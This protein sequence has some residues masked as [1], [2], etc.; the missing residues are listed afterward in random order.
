MAIEFN[1]QN[2]SESNSF[3]RTLNLSKGQ[4]LNLEKNGNAI[5]NLLV[6][7]GWDANQ[8]G[9]TFDLDASV[10]LLNS[11]GVLPE[12]DAVVYFNNLKAPGMEH[13]GD[14]LTGDGDGDDEQIT[15][16]LDQV[17]SE[18]DRIVFVVNIYDAKAKK[19]SFGSVKNSYISLTDTN[20]GRK[21]LQYNLKDDYSLQT[22]VIVA[23]L[24]RTTKGWTFHAIGEG[25]VGDLNDLVARYS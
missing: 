16:D 17:G 21:L 8:Y 5:K 3:S 11:K 12:L 7:L 18:I 22:G 13:H 9:A 1:N 15:I 2:K 19:Q 6:G 4:S 14:N 24:I 25:V 20:T 10:F 23:E